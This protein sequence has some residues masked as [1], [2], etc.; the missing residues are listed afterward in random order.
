MRFMARALGVTLLPLVLLAACSGDDSGG[1]SSDVD[2]SGNYSL[3]SFQQGTNPVLGPPVAT[4][5]L[6]MTK[7]RYKVTI[8]IT[9]PVATTILD[10][11][12]YTATSTTITQNSDVQPVQSTGTWTRNGNLFSIDVTALGNRVVSTWQKQ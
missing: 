9:L 8:N 1:P 4:G 10:S 6:T 11:G 7:T 5:S 12:T 3:V 2:F